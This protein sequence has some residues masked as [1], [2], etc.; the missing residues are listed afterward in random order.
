MNGGHE[1]PPRNTDTNDVFRA[2]ADSSR[3]RLLDRLRERNGQTL[4]GLCAGLGM[5]RQAV[6]KHLRILEAANL[7]TTIRR[8][9]EKLH[10][11]NAV[12]IHEI[13][14]RWI[15]RYEQQRVQLLSD[16]K[17]GLEESPM[18]KPAFVYTTYIKTTPEELWQALTDPSFTRR[19][20]GTVFTTDWKVGSP[21][22]WEYAGVSISDPAQVVLEATPYRRL[23][24]TWQ[25]ITPEFAKA[26]GFSDEYFVKAAQEP[27]SKVTFDLEPMG[28]AVKLTVIHDGF[29][30]G[31][32]TLE[33][34]SGGW[35]ALLSALKSLLETG[36]PLFA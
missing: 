23:S 27:R 13:A 29:E 26:V 12:P 33:S 14:E 1:G 18:E 2:L 22:T 32:V 25:T 34:I 31:S 17:R 6:T 20:W 30:P 7:I 3:R 10:Y 21:M 19:Y 9:R 8:G 11:L 4:R 5:T 16:L 15:N 28:N 24:Y 36:E 35:P